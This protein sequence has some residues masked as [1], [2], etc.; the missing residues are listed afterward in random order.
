MNTIEHPTSDYGIVKIHHN[1]DWSGNVTV[2]WWEGDY[3]KEAVL[4]GALL[5]AIRN[6]ATINLMKR[7]LVEFIENMPVTQ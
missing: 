5:L 1:S 7:K 6:R 4:P 2:S 3:K